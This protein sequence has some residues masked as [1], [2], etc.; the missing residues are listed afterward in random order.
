M[1]TPWTIQE[2]KDFEDWHESR[3]VELY[4]LYPEITKELRAARIK[5]LMA[6][7]VKESDDFE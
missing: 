2:K 4:W 6:I 3:L 1:V 5:W 7:K